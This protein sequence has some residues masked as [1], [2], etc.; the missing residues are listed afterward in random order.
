M[1]WTRRQLLLGVGIAALLAISETSQA[2]MLHGSSAAPG[3]SAQI[4]RIGA[5]GY[6]RGLDIAADGTV[7]CFT[8]TYGAYIW[9]A[10]A[11]S[12]GNAGGLGSW[13]Q[14]ISTA[15]ISSSDPSVDLVHS[16]NWASKHGCYET[17][18][19]KSN[20]NHIWLGF[21]GYL[22]KS[23]NKGAS[24]AN[25]TTPFTPATTAQMDAND[26]L[27][28]NNAGPKLAIDPI[29]PLVVYF[30]MLGSRPYYTFD[31]GSTWTQ[32]GSGSMAAPSASWHTAIAIDPR[33]STQ[34]GGV[35][36][37]GFFA[38]YGTGVYISTNLGSGTPTFT[39]ISGSGTSNTALTTI[40][41]MIVDSQGN[42]WVTDYTFGTNNL[43]RYSP[44]GVWT[45]FNLSGAGSGFYMNTIAE[46]PTVANGARIIALGD[47]GYG[48]FTNN[49][50]AATPT[51]TTGAGSPSAG[52]NSGGV[53][54]RV[55]T[56]APVLAYMQPEPTMGEVQFDST[57]QAWI[58]TGIGVF[59]GTPASAA[60]SAFNWNSVNSGI[61]GLTTNIIAISSNGV[62]VTASYDRSFYV[63][64]LATYP[65]T[66]EPQDFAISPG[67]VTVDWA[68]ADPATFAGMYYGELHVY[69]GSSWTA[70][71]TG[72]TAG[73]GLSSMAC[74]SATTFVLLLNGGNPQYTTNA[75]VS[76]NDLGTYFN[77]TFSVPLN[78]VN[79]LNREQAVCADRVAA[80]T[81]YMHQFGCIFRSTNGGA[82]W[83]KMATDGVGGG[84]PTGSTALGGNPMLRSVNGKQG[85]LIWSSGQTYNGS[86]PY[87][88]V[89]N[90]FISTD[91]GATWTDL[92]TNVRDV[93]GVDTGPQVGSYPRI[94]IWGYVG[95]VGGFWYSD[96]QGSTWTQFV[97][98]NFDGRYDTVNWIE[99]HKTNAGKFVVAYEGSGYGI[100]G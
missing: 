50:Q 77:T 69:N 1:K 73:G 52:T 94:I 78:S 11:P 33:A 30:G 27:L 82:A 37:R 3:P 22:L 19:C 47:I 68:T 100:F 6:V 64:N 32:I 38:P 44:A 96:N 15:T 67:G 12:L 72:L 2:R 55:A 36:T 87:T 46:D 23:T 48:C 65:L 8:D 95:G 45:N 56:D 66:C 4:L 26:G 42:L 70:R 88:A 20:S 71:T 83:T 49:A 61:E 59:R 90:C 18:I 92:S 31:G 39:K 62:G 80:N 75:G 40:N 81:F 89:S 58:A 17:R 34:A 86:H 43:W 9:D 63:S 91:G 24:F 51:W 93:W 60:N 41:R 97:G 35:S 74:A 98:I 54:A 84:I 7:V 25:V 10:T 57:G 28:T 76:F 21:Q 13:R 16:Q 79:L 5:A 99:A 85:H 14:L 53:G 29:N